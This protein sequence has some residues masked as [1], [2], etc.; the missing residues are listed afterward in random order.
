[1]LTRHT[2]Y[3]YAT[4]AGFLCTTL[5]TTPKLR[6]QS[7]HPP[8]YSP[9]F[10]NVSHS[11]P[12][13]TPISLTPP[14]SLPSP[15]PP[16]ESNIPPDSIASQEYKTIFLK[17][18][19]NF[20]L[21]TAD[22][23]DRRLTKD[24]VLLLLRANNA[25]NTI[26]GT[27]KIA[28]IFAL[29]SIIHS[30]EG[31]AFP[32][33]LSSNK[34]QNQGL[35][36]D[37]VLMKDNE[38]HD[39]QTIL[40]IS[41]P[42]M[43][44]VLTDR[45][46]ERKALTSLPF[47][48]MSLIGK[49]KREESTGST[50][51]SHDSF[52]KCLPHK[53]R[54]ESFEDSL[55]LDQDR[56]CVQPTASPDPFSPPQDGHGQL[57]EPQDFHGQTD[58]VETQLGD[59][60]DKERFDD[61]TRGDGSVETD[62]KCSKPLFTHFP[63]ALTHTAFP[64]SSPPT[65]FAQKPLENDT[66]SETLFQVSQSVPST[67]STPSSLPLNSPSPLRSS[68]HRAR[69]SRPIP[70][71]LPPLSLPPLSF[72]DV[73]GRRAQLLWKQSKFLQSNDKN[74]THQH[75]SHS[76]TLMRIQ[77]SQNPHQPLRPGPVSLTPSPHVKQMIAS[78]PFTSPFITN[79]SLP[80]TPKAF[81]SHIPH[82]IQTPSSLPSSHHTSLSSILSP[83]AFTQA[84]LPLSSLPVQ[85][86]HPRVGDELLL[87]VDEYASFFAENL[88][89]LVEIEEQHNVSF[90]RRINPNPP[91]LSVR[92]LSI[93]PAPTPAHPS[94][95][96]VTVVTHPSLAS[97]TLD[98]PYH[99]VT[100]STTLV[101]PLRDRLDSDGEFLIHPQNVD[102][103]L[104]HLS[105]IRTGSF[106]LVP[107]PHDCDA[108]SS[109]GK[110]TEMEWRLGIMLGCVKSEEEDVLH[111]A[112]FVLLFDTDPISV[113]CIE[114]ILSTWL[115]HHSSFSETTN[116]SFISHLASLS[117]IQPSSSLLLISGW[118]FIPATAQNLQNWIEA[119]G[120]RMNQDITL[121]QFPIP[122]SVLPE[123]SIQL[124]DEIMES[125]VNPNRTQSESFSE[126]VRIVLSFHPLASF[127]PYPSTPESESPNSS[128]SSHSSSTLFLAFV[129]CE[130]YV[131]SVMA[132]NAEEEVF[133]IAGKVMLSYLEEWKNII[134]NSTFQKDEK[135]NPR[136]LVKDDDQTGRVS[137]TKQS[138]INEKHLFD[139]FYSNTSLWASEE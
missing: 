121:S 133:Q 99:F 26:R 95:R 101:L 84:G 116:L 39:T 65:T 30:P 21:L 82:S 106:I 29:H 23:L 110:G 3:H 130:N 109:N 53:D 8:N 31:L 107:S 131:S 132:Q 138:P 5:S 9:F 119:H 87:V 18:G 86:K 28:A 37:I 1:M 134:L 32:L 10:P 36:P 80:T 22:E 4:R 42:E 73:L 88:E 72:G 57:E 7:T 51:F 63:T 93:E 11:I 78:T 52:Q 111:R 125:T 137:L 100:S 94:Q 6:L 58:D 123:P 25:H 129:E 20:L 120:G 115:A 45:P 67:P 70:A 92:V 71:Q 59:V 15:S 16:L 96:I 90:S 35:I 47:L 77:Q 38:D 68:P 40:P 85:R 19:H 114:E 14:S 136:I 27:R 50:L 48:P 83:I 46:I 24:E 103:A 118:D 113:K 139:K 60:M 66:P 44:N 74:G 43:S 75:L 102:S 64:L 33:Q 55:E 61:R 2:H 108:T 17:L 62:A 41:V 49:V 127:F 124:L 97:S 13:S 12:S 126:S 81:S 135:K 54:E 76:A 112:W 104:S 91:F 128:L 56:D 79:R 105:L 89:E 98:E 69:L 117:S 122:F 34:T